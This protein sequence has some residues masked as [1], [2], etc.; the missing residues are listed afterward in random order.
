MV[1]PHGNGRSKSN[2]HSASPSAA[3]SPVLVQVQLPL[4]S[5]VQVPQTGAANAIPRITASFT[6]G[7]ATSTSR[8][9][10]LEFRFHTAA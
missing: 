6:L 3:G 10:Q 1:A 2:C 9:T 7:L 5:A 8:E 4:L